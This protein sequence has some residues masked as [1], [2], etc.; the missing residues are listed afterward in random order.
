MQIY[1]IYKFKI[2]GA[3]SQYVI[4][5]SAPRHVLVDLF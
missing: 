4:Y 5:Q 2:L 3:D 1:G